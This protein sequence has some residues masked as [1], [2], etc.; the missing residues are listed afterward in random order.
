MFG[1]RG[2]SGSIPPGV[3][4]VPHQGNGQHP[5][6]DLTPEQIPDL[7][8]QPSAAFPAPTATPRPA[9]PFQQNGQRPNVPQ[10]TAPQPPKPSGSSSPRRSD[11]YYDIKST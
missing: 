4:P 1:K 2:E 3:M 11:N 7:K 10:T 5:R 6:A 9:P 8:V